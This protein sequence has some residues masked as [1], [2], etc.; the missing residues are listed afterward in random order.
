MAKSVKPLV[1]LEVTRDKKKETKRNI[2]SRED[3]YEDHYIKDA[4][5]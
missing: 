1:L 4:G 5:T 2:V 3:L